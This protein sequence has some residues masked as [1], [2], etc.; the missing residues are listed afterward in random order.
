MPTYLR[1]KKLKIPKKISINSFLH[2]HTYTGAYGKIRENLE[3]VT[4]LL[5][6]IS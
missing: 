1:H 6:Y 2:I 5:G 4:F 3:K